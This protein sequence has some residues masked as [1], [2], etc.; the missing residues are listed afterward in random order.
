MVTA[1]ATLYY[2]MLLI[3]TARRHELRSSKCSISNK[4]SHTK[5]AIMTNLSISRK[6]SSFV[7][8]F[9][10]LSKARVFQVFLGL[11]F[12]LLLIRGIAAVAQSVASSATTEQKANVQ[13]V[14]TVEDLTADGSA[15][16]GQSATATKVESLTVAS[17]EYDAAKE[18]ARMTKRYGLSKEQKAKIQPLLLEQQ[19]QVHTLGEDVSL[20]DA[21]WT[22][23]VRKV[24]QQTVLKVRKQL[25]DAQLS[26]YAKDE[27]NRA[28]KS[29]DDSDDGDDGPPYGPPPDGGPGGPGGGGPGGGGPGGGGPPD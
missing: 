26:K 9:G 14:T 7:N 17:K 2:K 11:A 3:M 15:T 27:A 1:K 18:L 24:H 5:R 21:E 4:A 16:G 25:T 12:L 6:N 8:I 23:A 28:K 19:K 22:A 20:T 29:G 13:S 10:G